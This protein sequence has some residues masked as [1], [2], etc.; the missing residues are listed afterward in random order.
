MARFGT[1]TGGGIGGTTPSGT[2]FGLGTGR[3]DCGICPAT[4]QWIAVSGTSS[5]LH[6]FTSRFVATPTFRRCNVAVIV[7]APWLQCHGTHG[8]NDTG[9]YQS[10]STAMGT[11]TRNAEN[12][13]MATTTTTRAIAVAE[14]TTTKAKA[15]TSSAAAIE[16]TTNI[17]K[18][19]N[20][21]I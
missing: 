10:T 12:D 8:A 17:R 20:G 2:R 11:T 6:E 15:T 21:R 18:I 5:L 14:A 13:A 4:Q 7:V 3:H 16:T 1:S 19:R 9:P